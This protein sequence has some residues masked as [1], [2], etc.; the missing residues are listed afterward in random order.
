MKEEQIRKYNLHFNNIDI[1]N[2]I[3]LGNGDFAITLDQTG[4]QSLYNDFK[5]IPLTCISNKNWFY[6]DLSNIKIKPSY[7]DGKSYMLY[8]HDDNENYNLLRRYP[9]KYS[10]MHMV[11]LDESN[12]IINKD[13]ISNQSSSLDL[14]LGIFNSSFKYNNKHVKTKT[15]IYQDTDELSF[16]LESSNLRLALIFNF[17][18]YEKKGYKEGNLNIKIINDKVSLIYD[19][20]NSLS[21]NIS[22]NS[23]YILNNNMLIFNETTLNLNLSLDEIKN[24]GKLLDSFWAEDNGIIIDDERLSR[25]MVLSKYLL[26]V[27]SSGI[28]PPSEAGLTYNNWNSKFH[29]E[30]HLIHSLWNLYNN[31][32]NDV[33]KSFDYYLS[34]YSISEKRANLNGYKGIRLPKMTSPDGLDSP[35][36]I[37]PLL[38]WQ[39]PHI[40]FM[41]QEIY[42][43]YNR[44]DILIKYEPLIKGTLD[45]MISLFKYKDG[46]YQILDPIMECCEAIDIDKCANPM[47]E[48]EYFRYVLQRQKSIDIVMYDKYQYD[49]DK[50]INNLIEPKIDDGI[51][52]KTGMIKDKYEIYKDHPTEVFSYSY[53]KSDRI[54]NTVMKDTIDY[55]INNMDLSSYWGWDFPLM[56]LCYLNLGF[57]KES[58]DITL[59]DSFNNQ[60]LYNGHNTSLRDDLKIYLP[61]NGAFLLYYYFLSLKI[62]KKTNIINKKEA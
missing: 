59:Y 23:K 27:N 1:K 6:K 31:H 58:I 35:S 54:N 20:K 24:K 16:S 30:M 12:N 50:Y 28:Y 29:L 4:T 7:I 62:S 3:T 61:G 13:L 37:G 55:V 47:F 51:Y 15:L 33:L 25:R 19:D 57:I 2:P 5:D 56:G 21:F 40:L 9:H 26:H 11:L 18:S 34:I 41:L 45:F 36:N 8:N 53:F 46:K 10:F 49:Y 17:P 44:T 14:Y 38:I 43:I 42:Y 32:L 48:I 52:L 22:S 60:Y 39:V